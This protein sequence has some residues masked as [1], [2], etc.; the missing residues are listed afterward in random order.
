MTFSVVCPSFVTLLKENQ[1]KLKSSKDTHEHTLFSIKQFHVKKLHT[2][3]LYISYLHKT[4]YKFQYSLQ[5]IIT[6]CFEY[7]HATNVHVL[8]KSYCILIIYE[9]TKILLSSFSFLIKFSQVSDAYNP[10]QKLCVCIICVLLLTLAIS[11]FCHVTL[12]TKLYLQRSFIT[13][14]DR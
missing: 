3:Y 9:R 12:N 4:C 14:S 10:T 8:G 1:V 2:W 13:T 5:D 7:I 11:G 6:L